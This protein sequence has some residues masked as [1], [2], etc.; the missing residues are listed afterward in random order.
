MT[1]STGVIF[2]AGQQ[3]NAPLCDPRVCAPRNLPARSR[4]FASAKAGAAG[5]K[6]CALGNPTFGGPP[7]HALRV[8][9]RLPEKPIWSIKP[10]AL[11]RKGLSPWKRFCQRPISAPLFSVGRREG[12]LFA[13]R[14]TVIP[15]RS[16][17]FT[18]FGVDRKPTD[19]RHEQAWFSWNIGADIPRAAS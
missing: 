4:G 18:F 19:V 3:R 10:T 12:K 16:G 15:L 6:A 7:R 2:A 14:K 1:Y 11:G 17:N 9:P 5:D 13:Q 8:A